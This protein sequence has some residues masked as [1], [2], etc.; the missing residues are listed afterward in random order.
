MSKG[1]SLMWT[2]AARYTDRVGEPETA[3][4]EWL[5]PNYTVPSATEAAREM[6][7]LAPASRFTLRRR[8]SRP[9]RLLKTL[10]KV[11]DAFWLCDVLQQTALDV[12]SSPS[13]TVIQL[14][15]TRAFCSTTL[16]R[17]HSSLLTGTCTF[18]VFLRPH[19]LAHY[20]PRLRP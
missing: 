4:A 13:R 2:A 19:S 20:G 12:Y 7:D 8:R 15:L 9:R 6:R 18:L 14:V 1:L 3:N 11:N 10:L 5:S 16:G 17:A